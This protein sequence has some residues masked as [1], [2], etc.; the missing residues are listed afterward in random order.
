MPR[1]SIGGLR[2]S[3]AAVRELRAQVE[4]YA[5]TSPGVELAFA[6]AIRHAEDLAVGNP[7]GFARVFDDADLRVIVIRRFPYRLIYRL[8]GDSVVVV[9]IAHTAMRPRCFSGRA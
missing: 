6:E 3:S 1:R 7:Q 5:A 4:H 2:Y 8:H 9:A